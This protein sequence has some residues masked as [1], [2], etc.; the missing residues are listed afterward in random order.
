MKRMN[1][2]ALSLI[3]ILSLV[4]I[5]SFSQSGIYRT[6]L[7][8]GV[9]QTGKDGLVNVFLGSSGDHGQMSPAASYPFGMISIGP[10]TY[11][12][13]HMGYEYKAKEFLGFTHTRMEGVGCKGSGGNILITPFLGTALQKGQLIKASQAAGPGYYQA[14][15]T[16]NIKAA[17]TVY[18]KAGLHQYQFPAGEKGFEIDLSHTLDNDFVAEEHT[19]AGNSISGWVDAKTTCNAGKYRLYY[20]LQFE[21]PVTM[22]DK[23]NHLLTVK[24]LPSATQVQI[25]I[26]LSS[27]STE[28][29]K[30]SLRTESYDL[31]K[32]KSSEAWSNILKRITVKGDPQ[33]EKLFYSLLY[34]TIQS[35]YVISEMD[36]AFKGT[37]GSLQSSTDTMYNGWAIWDNYRTQL[38]LLS[39]AWPEKYQG[40]VTSIANLYR[41]GKKGYATQTEPSNTVRTEHAIVVLLD[42]IR[43]GYKVPTEKIMDSLISE[44]DKLDFSSPDKALESCYD[45]W[46]LSQIMAFSNRT[47]QSKKYKQIALRYKEYWNKDFKDLSKNDVDRMQARG[48]YQGTIWQY[49]WFVPY[50]VKGLIELAGGEEAFATQLDRFFENDLYNHANEPDLQVPSMYNATSQLYKSQHYMH[51]YAVDTVVQYYFND[52]SRGVDPFVDVIYQNKP[53]TYIRT[54]DDDAGAMSAWYVLTACGIMPACVGSPEYYLHVPL[55]KSIT[56]NWPGKKRLVITVEN[57]GIQNRYISKVMLNGKVLDRNYITHEELMAGGKLIIVAAAK[58]DTTWGVKERWISSLEAQ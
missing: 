16:N 56:F 41:F 17:F 18:E 22:A 36:G 57:E 31:L 39:L 47:E 28:Y 26:A 9:A 1:S 58:P 23:G 2:K 42:A 21:Q 51:K 24:L 8:G 44:V 10:Q 29:A 54:M 4:S 55:F 3:T 48:L 19:V 25:R 52:N 11:P 46:A 7:K 30:Q 37:D 35:P 45:A 27:I 43:K 13:L 33:R 40:M 20:Y 5:L 53:D 12:N 32:K 15:F 34:R 50:D 49:R 14:S 38:P 6:S